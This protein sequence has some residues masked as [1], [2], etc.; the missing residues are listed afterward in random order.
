M[1]ADVALL[2]RSPG[3]ASLVE[4]SRDGLVAEGVGKG[5]GKS[6]ST[7]GRR[8]GRLGL[9]L[10]G[11]DEG[12][13]RRDMRARGARAAASVAVRPSILS[14]PREG[15]SDGRTAGREFLGAARIAAS[16]D[17]RPIGD[18]IRRRPGGP[19][20]PA[21]TPRPLSLENSAASADR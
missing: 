10:A 1:A 3:G 20:Q 6:P 21:A 14:R 9:K 11:R 12:P 16:S 2:A 5:G 7:A 18:E 19:K 17:T 8:P 15:I 13:A 4:A